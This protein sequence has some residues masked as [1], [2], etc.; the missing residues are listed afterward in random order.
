MNSKEIYFES[1]K[2]TVQ[3]RN[4]IDIGIAWNILNQK[5]CYLANKCLEFGFDIY[6][7]NNILGDGNFGIS[8]FNQDNFF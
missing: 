7:L 5:A 6:L 8:I 4:K 3:I 1:L 2:K